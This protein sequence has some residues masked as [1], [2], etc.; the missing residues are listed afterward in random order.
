MEMLTQIPFD[1]AAIRQERGLSLSQIA[2]F[3]KIRASWLAA[4]EE[5]RWGELPGG[6][7]RRSYIRQ[8]ARATGVN[9]G[10]L[11]ACCPPHL[12]AEA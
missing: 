3:T 7:Y 6:I 10:E 8:Y 4:I 12:L 11:L 5:G 9:E 2:E 1:L